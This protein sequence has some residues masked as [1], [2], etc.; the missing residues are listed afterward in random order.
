MKNIKLFLAALTIFSIAACKKDY[1]VVDPQE[2]HN[3]EMM[4]Y[5]VL[6]MKPDTTMKMMDSNMHMHVRFTEEDGKMIHH[7]SVKIYQMDDPTNIIYDMPTDKHVM[8][9]GGLYEHHDDLI[10]SAANG[11][12]P[13]KMYVME[14]KVWGHE[15]GTHEKI[16]TRQFHIH[17]M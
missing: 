5:A 4:N 1:T 12:V 8:A 9:A 7:I 10:L 13:H 3:E 11:V 14:A 16:V 6:I 2:Q 17:Q 15:G